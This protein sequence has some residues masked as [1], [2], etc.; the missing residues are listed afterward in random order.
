MFS[1][2]TPQ[3]LRLSSRHLFPSYSRLHQPP[4]ALLLRSFAMTSRD[5]FKQVTLDGAVI[6]DDPDPYG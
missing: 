2:S 4:T 3:L 5:E 6:L 1:I